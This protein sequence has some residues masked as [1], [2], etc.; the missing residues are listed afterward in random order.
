METEETEENRKNRERHRS[1]DPFCEIPIFRVG[2]IFVAHG[3]FI[4]SFFSSH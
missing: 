1:G 2:S 4:G 3:M